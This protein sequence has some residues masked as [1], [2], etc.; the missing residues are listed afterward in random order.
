MLEQSVH[1][2]NREIIL[3]HLHSIELNIWTNEMKS[4]RLKSII[5]MCINNGFWPTN[6]EKSVSTHA[7]YLIYIIFIFS[8]RIWIWQA[9]NNQSDINLRIVQWYLSQF[10]DFMYAF[11]HTL[12]ERKWPNG[13]YKLPTEGMRELK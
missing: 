13:D 9:C 1:V 2:N 5:L 11:N 7:I 10:R 4:E 6:Y 3:N 12:R 8:F